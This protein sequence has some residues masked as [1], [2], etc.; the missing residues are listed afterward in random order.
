MFDAI[1]IWG[2]GPFVSPSRILAHVLR[3]LGVTPGA[4]PRT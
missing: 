1:V 2:E 4:P 3:R